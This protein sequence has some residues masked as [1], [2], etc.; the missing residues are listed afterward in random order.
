MA[1]LI[2]YLSPRTALITNI[3]KIAIIGDV[4]SEIKK[5]GHI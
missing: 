5:F 2:H 1:P 3:P 4:D